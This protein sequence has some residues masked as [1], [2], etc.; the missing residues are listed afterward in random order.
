MIVALMQIY[1]HIMDISIDFIFLSTY[2][3]TCI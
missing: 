1:V 3:I 2:M